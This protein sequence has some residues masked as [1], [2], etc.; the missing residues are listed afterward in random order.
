MPKTKRPAALRHRRGNY[1]AAD[2]QKITPCP[3]FY[4]A[5][6]GHD[7]LYPG[8]LETSLKKALRRHSN[9]VTVKAAAAWPVGCYDEP[10]PH[11][12]S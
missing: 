5:Y 9:Q 4:N 7:A 10:P 12:E 11:L 3:Q 2:N 1:L 6:E 8:C